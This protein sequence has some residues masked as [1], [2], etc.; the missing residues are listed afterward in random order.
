MSKTKNR[1]EIILQIISAFLVAIIIVQCF[2]TNQVN[3][4]D[5][6]SPKKAYTNIA[7]YQKDRWCTIR[8]EVFGSTS[9]NMMDR[10]IAQNE[11]IAENKYFNWADTSSLDIT[12][13][14]GTTQSIDGTEVNW[15]NFKDEATSITDLD[16]ESYDYSDSYENA[17]TGENVQ[18]NN[19]MTYYVA[20]VKTAEEF[21]WILFQASKLNTYSIKINIEKDIDLNGG[22]SK[23]WKS[24]SLSGNRYV[25][26][27]GNGHTIYNFRNA[28]R[29]YIKINPMKNIIRPKSNKCD[30]NIRPLTVEEQEKFTEF[31]RNADIE[32]VPY[33]NVFLFQMYL[34]MRVGEVLALKTTDIDLVHNLIAVKHTMSVDKRERVIMKDTPK[35]FNGMREL[36][37]PEFLKPYIVE[38][39]N[40]AIRNNHIENL[41]FVNSAGNFV[42][43]RGANKILKKILKDNF[44]IE[45]ISTHSLRHTFGTRCVEGGMR[46]VAL[47]R[48]MGHGSVSATLDNYVSISE[49]YTESELEKMYDYFMKN[50]IMT[51]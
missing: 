21:R 51:N 27:E 4:S 16:I 41:L 45:D 36:P 14:N 33:K 6:K 5:V 18:V 23:I 38:Q 24:I 32:I 30:K 40:Y 22:N 37:I 25:Y 20:N 12:P 43:H 9:T 10:D 19:N 42:D 28:V 17:V 8:K 46:D 48:L 44:N 34:G 13:W 39:I 49:S 31:L 1:I 26:I 50:N 29:D 11:V 2:Q 47:Q 7:D 3:L 15:S 35:S